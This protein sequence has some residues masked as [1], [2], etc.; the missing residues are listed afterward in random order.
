MSHTTT[1]RLATCNLNQWALDFEGNLARIK[2]SI[3]K[4]KEDGAR[5]RVGPELEIPGY[6][7]EDHFLEG[8]TLRHTWECIADLLQGDWTDNILVDIGAPVMHRNV[9]YNC[10]I[11]MYDRK[12]WLIRPKMYLANDGNYRETR[13]F[14]SWEREFTVEDYYLPRSIHAITG[15]SKTVPFGVACIACTDTVLA[16]ETCEELF[17][18]NAPNIWLSLNGIEII[19]NGSASHHN[20]RKLNKRIE[21]L[22]SATRK[23][24]GV[25]LY[26]NQQGCDGGRLYYD[27]SAMVFVNGETVA[28]ASQFSMDDVEVITAVVDLSDIRA[29]RLSINSRAVQG[30]G[31]VVVPRIDVPFQLT[32]NKWIAPTPVIQPKIPDPMEEIGYGPA[33]WL[34]DYL[35][36]SKL[37][38]YFLPLSGGADS[39]A[40]A[41]IVGI[42]CQ[43]VVHQVQ[44]KKCLHTLQDV[45]AI[46]RNV[47]YIP[48]DAQEFAKRIFFTCYM[49]TKF[50]GEATTTRAKTLAAEI[51]A[52]HRTINIDPMIAAIQQIWH[53]DV[54]KERTPKMAND[55]GSMDEDLALQN[56]Q[57]RSRM[58][59]GYFLSQLLPWS[60]AEPGE[61]RQGGLLVLGSANVDEALR[62]YFTKYD[63]SAADLNPIGSVCKID[64]RSFLMWAGNRPNGFPTLKTIAQA[65]PTAEL[66]GGGQ[67]EQTDEQDMGMTYAELSLYGKL[68]KLTCCGPVT[69]YTKLRGNVEGNWPHLTGVEIARKV[70]HFF[71]NYAINRHKMTTLTPSYHAEAYSPDDNRH[72]LRPFL[73]PNMKWQ[74]DALEKVAKAQDDEK[75]AP[76]KKTPLGAH[77]C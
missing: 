15:G 73:Y 36:R 4:A 57:A 30:T 7:C 47:D 9:L 63:C 40:T 50:S 39:A 3:S 5:F 12:I 41:A 68:R 71:W 32:E 75:N 11:F 16:S 23:G 61:Q 28:Q 51:G 59:I 18:P 2:E 14:C 66:G 43:M 45:R 27:G 60:L 67:G 1:C 24:G 64:L 76:Q 53:D 31:S 25:Y 72:D 35:R 65:A 44:V 54:C 10:R 20:L 74:F 48:E 62:G 13:W 42:M 46:V 70:R 19:A 58:V 26:A 52:T 29:Y 77:F 22:Q 8:D 38:G 17:T 69:M 56:I 33:C 37:R 6:G 55:G 49:G 34:W 21:L